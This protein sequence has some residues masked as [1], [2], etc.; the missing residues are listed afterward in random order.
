M[1]VHVISCIIKAVMF[2][3]AFASL[4][5]FFA[6][7]FNSCLCKNVMN[8]CCKISMYFGRFSYKWASFIKCGCTPHHH[9]QSRLIALCFQV[10]WKCSHE[11]N[12]SREF[13]RVLHKCSVELEDELI[14][15]LHSKVKDI[16]T[17]INMLLCDNSAPI[18]T[19]FHS[20]DKWR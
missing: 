1:P 7:V 5:S 13:L 11:H 20:N 17:S 15:F 4:C 14:T 10:V 9:W 16:V 3:F 19:E 12:V 2:F 18:K 8:S 6:D